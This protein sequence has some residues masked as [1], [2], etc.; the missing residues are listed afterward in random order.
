MTNPVAPAHPQ[1]HAS[2]SKVTAWDQPTRIFHWLLLALVISAYIS[3]EFS[4][5]LGDTLLVWHRWNGLAILTLVLWRVLW[6]FAGSSTARFSSFVPSPAAAFRYASETLQGRAPR[7]LGHNPLGSVMIIALLLILLVQATLGLFATDDDAFTGGPLHRLVSE[8][9]AKE[10]ARRHGWIFDYLLLP[11]A[12][13]HIVTNTLY[14]WL[15]K[16]PLITAMVTGEKPA[17]A[18]ADETQATLVARPMLRAL[19]CL[20]VA[21]GMVFGSIA[22][23]GGRF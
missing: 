8:A 4:E 1:A 19:V 9:D 3:M 10:A 17:A 18:Y 12:G 14:G 13:L 22:A 16:E 7:Y 6:G 11:M 2:T 20:A 23:V 5:D 21:A 15:K